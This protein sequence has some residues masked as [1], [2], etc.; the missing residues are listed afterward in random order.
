MTSGYFS[1]VA[2]A[3]NAVGW[4]EYRVA[5][6]KGVNV[7]TV[8]TEDLDALLAAMR[9]AGVTITSVNRLDDFEPPGEEFEGV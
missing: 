6:D 4:S 3:G 8:Q 1:I 9:V 7:F 5:L 2:V